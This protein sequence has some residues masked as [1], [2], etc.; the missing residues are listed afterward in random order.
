MLIF[1][2]C[3]LELSRGVVNNIILLSLKLPAF[4]SLSIS[5]TTMESNF[6]RRLVYPLFLHQLTDM[7]I[8]KAMINCPPSS[9]SAPPKPALIVSLL[10]LP[11]VFNLMK[12]GIWLVMILPSQFWRWCHVYDWLVMILQSYSMYQEPLLIKYLTRSFQLFAE[13]VA[14]WAGLEDLYKFNCRRYMNILISR[15]N[16]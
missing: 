13:S 4:F 12:P 9:L 2:R 16:K 14:R 5:V 10:K 8:E 15:R 7:G 11:S 3:V 6:I 1:C